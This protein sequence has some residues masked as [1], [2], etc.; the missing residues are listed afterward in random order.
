MYLKSSPKLTG[1]GIMIWCLIIGSGAYYWHFSCVLGG[2]IIVGSLGLGMMLIGIW[3]EHLARSELI[4]RL[5]DGYYVKV[6]NQI[7]RKSVIISP[8]LMSGYYFVAYVNPPVQSE[9]PGVVLKAAE[10]MVGSFFCE[11]IVAN[12]W[13]DLN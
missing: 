12:S 13:D 5:A 10:K 8:D 6:R 4:E 2:C 7:T 9:K 3:L 11:Y 1:I